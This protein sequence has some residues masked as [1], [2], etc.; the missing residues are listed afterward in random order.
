MI[1]I[2]TA[3]DLPLL[4]AIEVAAGKPFRALGMTAVADDAPPTVADLERY[5]RDARLWVAVDDA[6]RPVGYAC[7]D[8]V[9]GCAHL[10]QVSIDPQWSGR[11]IGAA[12]IEEVSVWASR[13]GHRWLTLTTFAEVPWNAPYYRRLG[14]EPIPDTEVGPGLR[15]V[16]AREAEHGLDAWPRLAMRREC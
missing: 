7:A 14:F 16:R 9:D 10:D 3:A 1:R 13:G 6:G 2:A 4:P 12:L 5:L 15:A 11:R 8:V